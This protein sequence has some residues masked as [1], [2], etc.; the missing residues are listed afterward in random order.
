MMV[1]EKILKIFLIIFSIFFITVVSYN[2]DIQTPLWSDEN[3]A[4]GLARNSLFLE[5]FKGVYSDVHPP[6]YHLILKL[7]FAIF[8]DHV[9]A[10]RFPS[11]LF[12]I[13]TFLHLIK[14]IQRNTSYKFVFF[15]LLL[16]SWCIFYYSQEVRPYTLLLFLS[17][18]VYFN[19]VDRVLYKKENFKSFLVLTTL[20]VLVHYI[21]FFFIIGFYLAELLYMKK[22]KLL[23]RKKFIFLFILLLLI[24][25]S[26]MFYFSY[27]NE[28]RTTGMRSDY[29]NHYFANFFLSSSQFYYNNLLLFY[30]SLNFFK[31]QYLFSIFLLF[32]NLIILFVSKKFNEREIYFNNLMYFVPLILVLLISVPMTNHYVYIYL[33]I[34]FIFH[35]T[36]IIISLLNHRIIN[37][38]FIIFS[39]TFYFLINSLWNFSKMVDHWNGSTTYNGYLNLLAVKEICENSNCYLIDG[40]EQIDF[41]GIKK[42]INTNLKINEINKEEIDTFKDEKS[43]FIFIFSSIS[44][45]LKKNKNY[46]CFILNDNFFKKILIFT[47]N[48]LIPNYYNE[49]SYEGISISTADYNRKCFVM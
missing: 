19:I 23:F 47:K 42:Q 36:D 18:L 28:S 14:R 49:P 35:L 12:A 25:L 44:E 39:L 46:N 45:D 32:F 27:L 24:I 21:C 3:L 37:K 22:I 1:E 20:S 7:S 43:Q 38:K 26:H 4:I 29:F 5:F 6:L 9:F 41:F 13:F 8:G 33:L 11:Y 34:P 40:K 16:S 10:A 17:S 30:K 2:L 15:S 48:S 31:T